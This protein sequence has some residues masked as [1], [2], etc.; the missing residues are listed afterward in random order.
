LDAD[1]LYDLDADPHEDRNVA[2]ANPDVLA[3]MKEKL[4]QVRAGKQP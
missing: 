3:R 4:S 2:T 1:Q